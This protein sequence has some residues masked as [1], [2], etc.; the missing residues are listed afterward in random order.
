[1]VGQTDRHTP[2]RGGREAGKQGNLITLEAASP[3]A[4]QH[5]TGVWAVREAAGGVPTPGGSPRAG[6]VPPQE[7][8]E[9]RSRRKRV[10]G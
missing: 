3:A 7:G 1:M 8:R 5:L 9:G 4:R 6:S 10:E 2:R